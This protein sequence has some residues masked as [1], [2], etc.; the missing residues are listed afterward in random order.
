[1]HNPVRSRVGTRE[2]I[3]TATYLLTYLLTYATDDK[4][5]DSIEYRDT[6]PRY[7]SWKK[8]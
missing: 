4:Y 2:G 6:F 1:M 7:L 3:I 5:R 8:F